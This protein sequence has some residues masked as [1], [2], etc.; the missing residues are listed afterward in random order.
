VLAKH[1]SGI[2]KLDLSRKMEDATTLLNIFTNFF[3]VYMVF[4]SDTSPFIGETRF[5]F[6]MF[7]VRRT[8]TKTDLA[9]ALFSLPRSLKSFHALT[10][11]VRGACPPRG[12]SARSLWLGV[13]RRSSG[14]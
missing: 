2:A 6:E 13:R 9:P 4:A 1:Y 11:G 12:R 8:Y 14:S 3:A 5:T 10:W 7:Q